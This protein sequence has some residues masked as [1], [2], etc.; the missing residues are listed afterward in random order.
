MAEV[1]TESTIPSGESVDEWESTIQSG[2]SV[3]EWETIGERCLLPSARK[4]RADGPATEQ[5]GVHKQV[6]GLVDAGDA[7][8]EAV[9][10]PP[11]PPPTMPS[12]KHLE[13]S[14]FRHEDKA[15]RCLH[16]AGM[17][18]LFAFMGTM[19]GVIFGAVGG[20]VLGACVGAMVG[21]LAI[22][23][24]LGVTFSVGALMGGFTGV[25]WGFWFGLIFGLIGG[26]IVG[27]GLGVGEAVVPT[28]PHSKEVGSKQ[29]PACVSTAG[30]TQMA[31]T[32]LVGKKEAPEAVVR[33]RRPQG[34]SGSME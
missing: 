3:D 4:C 31:S 16:I 17:S 25:Y 12:A 19:F 20:L 15:W 33:R 21:L 22:F 34:R 5:K 14:S 24:S 7:P 8:A 9:G 6:K 1:K 26:G 29:Q 30:T 28:V 2:Q 13:I 27:Y 10:A 23:A 18:V 11:A 32:Q